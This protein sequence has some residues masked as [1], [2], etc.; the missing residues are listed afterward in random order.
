MSSA[1]A[2][3]KEGKAVRVR[4]RQRHLQ[5]YRRQYQALNRKR[6]ATLDDV[7]IKHLMTDQ[8]QWLRTSD[9]PAEL[10]EAK[11]SHLKVK[12]LLKEMTNES[13]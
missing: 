2:K 10:I 9:I 7:Y 6:S 13:H 4:Y 11:R 12:R 5:E 8:S 1:Y 3:T